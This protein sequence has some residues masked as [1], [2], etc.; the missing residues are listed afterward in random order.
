MAGRGIA[1]F[2]GTDHA[3]PYLPGQTAASAF[4]DPSLELTPALYARLLAHGFR[5]SGSFVY[6]PLCPACAA[7]RPVR[8]AV[9]A[10]RP[11][12]SQ[13]RAWRAS[14][15]A[16]T[17]TPRPAGYDAAHFALYQ[18]YLESRHPDGEMANGDASDYGR[19]LFACWGETLCIELRVG[20]RLLGVA[21]TDVV[22]G[23]L[24]AVYTFFDPAEEGLSP[25]VLAILA[26]VE[27]ARRWG[28]PHLYL[29]YWI[30]D[31]RKMRYKSEYRP[32]D[33]L[34]DDAW[35]RVGP[36]EPMPDG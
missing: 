32:L 21:V 31:C 33:V 34:I 27:L 8:I 9:D 6:R 15:P 3:C 19:F 22:P 30:A 12:R 18:R 1:L 10:F 35:R 36:G 11:K 24:S 16:L 2:R 13:R 28:L 14:A 5:R 26:Q 25:G 4:V 23:A 17:V 29:G 7:C 20:G